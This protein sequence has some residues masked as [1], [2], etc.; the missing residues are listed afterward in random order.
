MLRHMYNLPYSQAKAFGSDTLK[1]HIDVF[2]LADKYD[3]PS[4]RSAAVSSFRHTADLSITSGFNTG[5]GSLINNIANLCGS[6]A[7]QTAD[8]S[9]RDTALNFCAVNYS[10]LFTYIDFR[11]QLHAGSLFDTDAMH[12][13]LITLGELASEK[14]RSLDPSHIS[15]IDGWNCLAPGINYSSRSS[16]DG[17]LPK[18]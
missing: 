16:C 13:L 17:M 5:F 8:P 12:K 9:L 10:K 15:H 4:L 7:V 2:M 1:F 3:C 18:H 6:N 11:V 14:N